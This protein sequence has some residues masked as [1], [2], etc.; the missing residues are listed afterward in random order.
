MLYNNLA[1]WESKNKKPVAICLTGFLKNPFYYQRNARKI[2]EVMAP[3]AN[4]EAAPQPN[5]P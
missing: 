2:N 1:N 4:P 3:N 5:P